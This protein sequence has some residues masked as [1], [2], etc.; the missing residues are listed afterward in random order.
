M[1]KQDRE[2]D[3]EKLTCKTAEFEFWR[4]REA[5]KGLVASA[6]LAKSIETSPTKPALINA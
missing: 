3:R 6:Y 5:E 4:G 1:S 2:K